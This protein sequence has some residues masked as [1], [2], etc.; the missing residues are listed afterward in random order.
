MA[1]VD[2][3]R[4]DGRAHVV[5]VRSPLAHARITGIDVAA[6]R[7]A[8]GV[9]AVVTSADV[10]VFPAG[11]F[12][13]PIHSIFAQ[14]LLAESKVRF[15]GEPVAA[16][17]ADPV[18][19]AV[20]DALAGTTPLSGADDRA[21]LQPDGPDD[22]PHDTGN[23]VLSFERIGRRGTAAG[24]A[25][26]FRFDEADVVVRLR[27]V[28]PR[29]A[30]APIETRGMACAWDGDGHLTVWAATQRPHGARDELARLHR[31]DPSRITVI[32][33]AV[34]GGFG[35][36]NSRTPEETVLPL[37]ARIAGRPV[38]WI[39]TRSENLRAATAAR[40]E[41]IDLT[42][43]GSA[44]GRIRAVRAEMI[45]DGGAYPIT[46]VVLPEAWTWPL[47]AGPYDIDH[48][49]LAGTAVAT[50]MVATSAFRGAGRA[51]YI[52]GL[53][54]LVDRFAVEV[55]LDPA[56]VRRRNLVRA[57]DMPH[58]SATGAVY[59]EA[60]YG[61]DLEQALQHVGYD[62]LRRD[63]ARRRGDGAGAQL[64]IGIACYNHVTVGGGGE[65]ATVEIRT[66]GSALVVTG[67][68][69]QGHGHATTWAQLAADVLG[70]E[71]ARIDVVEG[72]TDL[73]PT[74]VGA[75]GSRSLQTAGVAFHRAADRVVD[76]GVRVAARLLEAAPGDVVLDV[77]R[78][79]FHVVGTPARSVGWVDVAA[80]AS[81]T[82]GAELRCGERYDNG[83]CDTYPSGCHVAVA[84][85]DTETGAVTLVRY[86]AVD[87]AGVRVNPMIVDGQLHGGIAAG[88]SQA[89]GEVMVYD[90]D[91]NPLT[92]TF[93]DYTMATAD[94]LVAFELHP[95]A[96]PSSFN[97][98][99]V[100]AVG[101][102]GTIGATPAVHNAVVGALTP[103]GVT[104]LDLPCTPMRVWAAIAGAA[105]AAHPTER[106]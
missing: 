26:R 89:F 10:D 22:G 2:D 58:T 87:D 85:V 61:A 25:E 84:E 51:P 68:T 101:E 64:G 20:D 42:L 16:V 21:R 57:G 71:P 72:R 50:T 37:L 88:I 8:L 106:P 104:H 19:A 86:V 34:G 36:R 78:G 28:N 70:I 82:D 43:A 99:G 102:S 45:K 31:L 44:A 76:N 96:T 60:D 94:Q 35:G 100:K 7:R 63:Q 62:E 9:I 77:G 73:I 53:E 83:G 15:V 4:L 33:P 1:D 17:V 23:V 56:E 97:E 48:V 13:A 92:S 81:A 49:E 6:V 11:R 93:L 46:G 47:A 59:D 32:A 74:G 98:L 103:F 18:T 54:R 30:P 38:S 65:E 75:V 29:Q 80:D 105:R 91:G 52:A 39:E 27:V 69:S 41:R 90:D 14:P 5:F 40:G 79:R 95:S 67:S 3:R 12:A 24:T 55:G 66:D